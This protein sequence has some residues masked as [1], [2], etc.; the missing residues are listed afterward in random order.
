MWD[1]SVVKQEN[2]IS[3]LPESIRLQILGAMMKKVLPV[4]DNF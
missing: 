1:W 4:I 3:V 2:D